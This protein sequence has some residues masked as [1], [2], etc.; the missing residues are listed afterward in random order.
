MSASDPNDFEN[1]VMIHRPGRHQGDD[2][3]QVFSMLVM[4]GDDPDCGCIMHHVGP[5]PS[6][7]A[8]QVCA[9]MAEGVEEITGDLIRRARR[10]YLSRGLK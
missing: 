4:P 1:A 9:D 7:E 8:A 2:A 3:W 10:A 5:F 6:R